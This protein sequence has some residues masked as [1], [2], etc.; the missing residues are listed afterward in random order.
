MIVQ[1]FI[2]NAIAR[3]NGHTQRVLWTAIST[4]Q[5]GQRCRLGHSR[6]PIF[7]GPAQQCYCV[8]RLKVATDYG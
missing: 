4:G 1:I 7:I 3:E 8:L 2:A 6:I 5:I